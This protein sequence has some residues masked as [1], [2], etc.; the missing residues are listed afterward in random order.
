M[1]LLDEESHRVLLWA[2]HLD[3]VGHA[4]TREELR[5][6]SEVRRPAGLAVVT[7]LSGRHAAFEEDAID[8]LL[9]RGLLRGVGAETVAPTALGRRVVDA[10]G[11]ETTFPTFEVL[12][13]DLSSGDPLA[14]ARIVGR[15]A[16]LHRPMVVDPYCR[17]SELEYLTAHTSVTRVLVSDRLDEDVVEALVDHV[18]S[19]RDREQKLRLRMAPADAIQD[20]CV[21]SDDRI[22][23]VGGLPAAGGAGASVVCEPHD[24]G[25]EI[26]G[27]YRSVWRKAERLAT[28]RPGARRAARVA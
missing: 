20:R 27:Y 13:V 12:D 3:D 2:V 17:R 9:R 18:G 7:G 19:I 23:H 11:L 6:L 26:R 22:L 28:Y 24:L 16:S 10:L 21:L 8:S 15:I 14:F 5:A 1:E 25:S 4:A